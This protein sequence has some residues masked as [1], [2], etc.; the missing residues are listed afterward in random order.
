MVDCNLLVDNTSEQERQIR[1]PGGDPVPADFGF[2]NLLVEAAHNP[3][4]S[5]MV[6]SVGELLL[7]GRRRTARIP[8]TYAKSIHYHD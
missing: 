7:D 3:M 1:Q 2:H 8:I 6:S 4:L 5:R